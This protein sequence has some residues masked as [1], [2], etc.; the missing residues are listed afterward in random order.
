MD[1]LSNYF[2][3]KYQTASFAQSSVFRVSC[4][5]TPIGQIFRAPYPNV[6]P[7]Q[8]APE[9]TCNS[10]M[11]VQLL[12]QK[13]SYTKNMITTFLSM[14]AISFLS[15]PKYFSHWTDLKTYWKWNCYL[16][17]V[18]CTQVQ[19]PG[20]IETPPSAQFDYYLASVEFH[21]LPHIYTN[22]CVR[23]TEM[24]TWMKTDTDSCILHFK[25]L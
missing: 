6:C 18:L 2:P 20:L 17:P 16:R 22:A 9:L 21:P 11:F 25:Y 24:M 4:P 10:N 3:R 13:K 8:S 12:C 19:F 7:S 1:T 23:T 14:A 15:E 5:G